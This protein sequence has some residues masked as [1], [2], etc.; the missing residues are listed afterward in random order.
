[1]T[2]VSA[3]HWKYEVDRW[4]IFRGTPGAPARP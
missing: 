3:N 4:F 2:H 1:M